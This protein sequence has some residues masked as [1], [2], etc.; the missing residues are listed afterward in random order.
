MMT[1]V[2]TAETMLWVW[3]KCTQLK[4]FHFSKYV[5]IANLDQMILLNHHTWF[6][7]S[8]V[9]GDSSWAKLGIVGRW[10]THPCFENRTW[11]YLFVVTACLR[12][13]CIQNLKSAC[14]FLPSYLFSAANCKSARGNQVTETMMKIAQVKNLQP[15]RYGATS[16]DLLVFA[17]ESGRI[18]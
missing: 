18:Q 2:G 13:S 9:S 8:P 12:W 4:L 6:D 15:F 5:C 17:Q 1:M 7:L 11:G 14:S 3:A 10:E 16:G